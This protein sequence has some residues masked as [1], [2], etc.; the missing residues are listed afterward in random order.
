[1]CATCG[2]RRVEILV[3][4]APSATH[5]VG[6]ITERGTPIRTWRCAQCET[7]YTERHIL[8]GMVGRAFARMAQIRAEH[9]DALARAYVPD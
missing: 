9:E 2:E 1:M 4:E 6:F 5:L 7:F 8:R 3:A